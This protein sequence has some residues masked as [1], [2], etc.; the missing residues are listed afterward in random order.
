MAVER[1]CVECEREIH[2][3]EGPPTPRRFDFAGREVARA[4]VAVGSGATYR[5]AGYDI[6]ERSGRLRYSENGWP[7]KNNDGNTVADWVEVFAPVIWK[8]HAPKEWPRVLALDALP[9]A[10]E[11]RDERGHPKQGGQPAF[12][13][14]GAYG[15][16][17]RGLGSMI[18]LRAQPN[19]RFK[20]GVPYWA[21][22]LEELREHFGDGMPEQIVVDADDDT[23]QAI[24]LV[25]PLTGP[26]PVVYVCHW[27][28]KKRLLTIL[29]QNY[30]DADDPLYQ[31]A[32]H[33]F[34]SEGHWEDFRALAQ[35]A[36]LKKL[37]RWLKSWSP[38]ITFQIAHQHGRKVATGPLEQMLTVVRHNLEDR[39]GTFKNRER[40]NR[41]L[42]LIQL[43][44]NKQANEQRYAKIIR[45]QLLANGGYS[46]PRREIV[47]HDGASLMLQDQ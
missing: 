1:E 9:F 10:I 12:H 39:R 7:L 24:E 45:E 47:D 6:R 26:S 43:D 25:W 38:R 2:R 17:A 21:T 5:R 13:V 46:L 35:A 36:R 40:L 42:M 15:W 27:H 41:L 31:A 28:L 20:Q 23:W 34:Y 37:D 22:F 18:A 4:L 44:L 30:L 14:F 16:D 19:F 3:H 32:D 11:A 8:Q 33:A 29:R